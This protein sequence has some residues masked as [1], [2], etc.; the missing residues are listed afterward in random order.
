MHVDICKGK[1]K[2]KI[3]NRIFLKS[4]HN[5]LVG[6]NPYEEVYSN[7]KAITQDLK[8][9]KLLVLKQVHGNK[10]LDTSNLWNISEEPEADGLYTK[11]N[12]ITLGI[13]TADCVPV[14]IASR[15]GDIIAGLHLGWKSVVGGLIK[16]TAD[17]LK[18]S[19]S[20][21]LVAVIG[22]SI[23]QKSYEV[24]AEYRDRFLN[25][26]SFSEEYF[27]RGENNKFF[28]N[29]PGIVREIMDNEGI[30]TIHHF[31]ED[32]YSN[33]DIYPSNRYSFQR[34]QKYK[35]SILSTITICE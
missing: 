18:K 3:Y 15:D 2:V 7:H 19:T 23:Q 9:E 10:I 13:Q 17:V 33:P 12:N 11:L 30:R 25:A 31:Q 27:A 1:V 4:T 29:L 35:G 14:L 26:F 5:Y 16:N 24:D 22:P 21:D 34:A 20:S 6:K 32:T 28:C 8:S